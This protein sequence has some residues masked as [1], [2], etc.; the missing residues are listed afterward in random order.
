MESLL[1]L[2]PIAFGATLLAVAL[3]GLAARALS[4]RPPGEGSAAGRA[5]RAAGGGLEAY[6]CGEDLP[7][8][9]AQPGYGPYFPFAFL[10]TIVH[11]AALVVATV[12]R[13]SP[14]ASALAAAFLAG[15]AVAIRVLLRR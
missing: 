13:G 10:F 15:A 3:Q 8:H 4:R 6:A 7:D 2:P 9:R 5:R 14:G 11:V 12:P 1:L